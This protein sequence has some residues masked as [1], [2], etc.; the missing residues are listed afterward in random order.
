MRVYR[1]DRGEENILQSFPRNVKRTRLY[2][3]IEREARSFLEM[4]IMVGELLSIGGK[5]KRY[6]GV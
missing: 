1:E 4:C 3:D 2:D 6:S 5:C